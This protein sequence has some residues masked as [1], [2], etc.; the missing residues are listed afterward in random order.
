MAMGV[1]CQQKPLPLPGETTYHPPIAAAANR[2][3]II[4]FFAAKA[5]DSSI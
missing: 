1:A 5:N 2:H 3:C 4:T